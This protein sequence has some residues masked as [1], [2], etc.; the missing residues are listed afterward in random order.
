MTTVGVAVV[1]WEVVVEDES[2]VVVVGA[3]EEDS[4]EEVDVDV[5]EVEEVV[6][7][8]VS[9]FEDEVVVDLDVVLV[10]DDSLDEVVVGW[11]EEE[12]VVASA[13]VVD[14]ASEET[15]VSD[16]LAP[17]PLSVVDAALLARFTLDDILAKDTGGG[18]TTRTGPESR[19]SVVRRLSSA[20]SPSQTGRKVGPRTLEISGCTNASDC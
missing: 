17:A 3:A 18:I 10:V 19:R 8:V 16:T 12:V 6:V 9:L 5:E 14:T 11:M 13:A 7:G 20:D 15:G 1:W 4:D 2:E